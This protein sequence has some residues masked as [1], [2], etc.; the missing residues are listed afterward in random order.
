MK[1]NIPRSS[2]QINPQ[3]TKLKKFDRTINMSPQQNPYWNGIMDGETQFI[4]M[5]KVVVLKQ[6]W[7]MKEQSQKQ[8]RKQIKIGCYLKV[9]L[10]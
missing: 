7:F 5:W 2:A 8:T 10:V 4:P 9:T 3:N 1:L 6:L